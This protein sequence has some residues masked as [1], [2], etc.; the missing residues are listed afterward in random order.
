MIEQELKAYIT[1]LRETHPDLV[2]IIYGPTATGKSGLSLRLADLFAKENAGVEIIS[3]DS[4]QVYKYMDIGTDK[5]SKE[6]RERVPHFGID[7]VNP[8]GEYSAH[9]RQQDTKKRISDIHG[10]GNLPVIVGGTGLYIDTIY[11]NFN[12]PQ[13]VK[14]NRE[15]RAELDA[16]EEKDP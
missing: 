11:K 6:D 8:D 16:L 1:E 7:L 12:L 5:I 3:A 4:R 10:R 13:D 9:Q 2:V 14:A 15:R